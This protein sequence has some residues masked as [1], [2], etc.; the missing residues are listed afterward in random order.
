MPNTKPA[1]LGYE[2]EQDF[3]AKYRAT[4]GL[5]F[6]AYGISDRL[7][8]EFEAAVIRATQE[9]SPDDT[10]TMPETLLAIAFGRRSP[11]NGAQNTPTRGPRQI[12]AYSACP[13]RWPGAMAGAMTARGS[14]PLRLAVAVRGLPARADFDYFRDSQQEDAE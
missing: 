8:I 3:R 2:L 10:S 12:G 6:L 14:T 11:V 4:E 5:I 13:T 7:A 1:E 9:K